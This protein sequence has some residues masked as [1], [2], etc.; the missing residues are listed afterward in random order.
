[1]LKAAGLVSEL[2]PELRSLIIPGATLEAV[3][4]IFKNTD[5]PSLSDIMSSAGPRGD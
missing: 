5:G 4:E 3:H 2:S 1:M